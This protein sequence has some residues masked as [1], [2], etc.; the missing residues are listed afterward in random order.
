MPVALK[1]GVHKQYHYHPA[2]SPEDSDGAQ[3]QE[4]LAALTPPSESARQGT[5]L[6]GDIFSHHNSGW[7]SAPGGQRPGMLL[8]ILLCTGQSS[9][10]EL[11][12]P[13]VTSG[14][15]EK[16]CSAPTMLSL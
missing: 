5:G 1:S 14:K 3:V 6:F 11:S 7:G 15:V 13:N 2:T 9:I 12:G 10:T 4:P 16:P 8:N